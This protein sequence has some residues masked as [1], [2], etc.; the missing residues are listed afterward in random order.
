MRKCKVCDTDISDR[1]YKA[2]FCLSCSDRKNYLKRYYQENKERLKPIRNEWKTENK[3]KMIIYYKERYLNLDKERL[4]KY[5]EEN[6]E[7]IR[8][9]S[10]SEQYLIKRKE[11]RLK[12]H[13]RIRYRTSLRC[14]MKRLGIKKND[15]TNILLGYSDLE[16]KE[17]IENQ[18][19]NNMS[20]ENR[21]SF[22]IDHIIPIVAFKVNTPMNIVSALDNLMPLDPVENL[23]KFISIDVKFIELYLKYFEY[24]TSEYQE[25]IKNLPI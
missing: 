3:E 24:L 21:S 19:I 15:Y 6:K 2:I 5:Y 25:K 18:F 23:N 17:H 11:H 9:R 10:K 8:E 20:W 12:N 22:E 13:W 7:R 14:V 4:Q 1:H 16:F